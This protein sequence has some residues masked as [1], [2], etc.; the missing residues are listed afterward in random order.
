MHITNILEDWCRVVEIVYTNYK[1]ELKRYRIIPHAIKFGKT[2]F[3]P[4][5]QWLMEATDVERNVMRT[6]SMQ[7]IHSWKPYVQTERS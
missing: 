1:G 4:I 6:F 2:E 7:T 5:E 3:H